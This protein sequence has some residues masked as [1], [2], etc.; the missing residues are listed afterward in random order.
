[1]RTFW[2]ILLASVVTLTPPGASMVKFTCDATGATTQIVNALGAANHVDECCNDAAG[3]HSLTTGGDCCRATAFSLP[4]TSATPT[5]ADAE[6]APTRTIILSPDAA[7]R[8]ARMGTAHVITPPVSRN[9]PL[10]V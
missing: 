2:N 5:H 1:M 3:T 4:L 10:L 8:H 6:P 7:T 9:L